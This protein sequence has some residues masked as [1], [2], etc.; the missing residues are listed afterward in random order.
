MTKIEVDQLFTLNFLKMEKKLFSPSG[1][2]ELQN[3]LYSLPENQFKA[4]IESMKL[5]FESWMIEHLIFTPTQLLF[6]E[7]M[8]TVAKTNLAFQVT[9]AAQFKKLITLSLLNMNGNNKRDVEPEPEPEDKL[10]K[11]KSSISVTS[12]GDGNTYV[13]G[14]LE[15]EVKYLI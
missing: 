3:W 13:E 2:M 11:P 6:Y 15:I 9:L 14:E 10:F 1:L 12:D 4:E 5:D 7:Q 8:A